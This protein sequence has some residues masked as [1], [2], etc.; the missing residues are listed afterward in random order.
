[1]RPVVWGINR[2]V[3]RGELM[4]D[5]Y[6]EGLDGALAEERTAKPRW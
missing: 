5:Q 6:F 3:N 1:M 4:K 2:K